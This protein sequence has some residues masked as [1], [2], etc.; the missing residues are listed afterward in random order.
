LTGAH[1]CRD[2]SDALTDYF[3]PE[4]ANAALEQVRPL[5]ERIVELRSELTAKQ[6]RQAALAAAAGGNGHG[7]AAREYAELTARLEAGAAELVECVGEIQGLGAQVKDLDLG[8]VDFPSLR[9]GREVLL[10]WRLGES[11]IHFWHGMDEGFSGR[12]PL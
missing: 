5:A 2:H 9:D 8:L 12:R 11:E 7:N 6:K 1:G 10:C 4:E 3:S